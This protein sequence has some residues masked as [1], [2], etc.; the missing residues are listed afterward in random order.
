MQGG[1]RWHFSL[2]QCANLTFGF[3]C[4][5]IISVP[6]LQGTGSCNSP[7]SI[8]YRAPAW[9]TQRV[10]W[11]P[12]QGYSVKGVIISSASSALFT[13]LMTWKLFWNLFSV[14]IL[15]MEAEQLT[16]LFYLL[17]SLHLHLNFH[18]LYCGSP[19]YSLQRLLF[20]PSSF[21]SFC[22]SIS[23]DEHGVS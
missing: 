10:S 9:E 1:K 20:Y 21:H 2:L 22:S 18:L 15:F 6:I 14:Q 13:T 5:D 3:K 11:R 7:L 17:H 4:P 19:T 8:V 23:V 16:I 12:T